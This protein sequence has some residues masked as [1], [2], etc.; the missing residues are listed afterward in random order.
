MENHDQTTQA[1]FKSSAHASAKKPS[2]EIDVERYDAYLKD[3]DLS[4]EQKRELL[5]ALWN[6][7][8]EFVS[9]GFGVHPL[10]QA[11]G[12]PEQ[13]DAILSADVLNALDCSHKK[14]RTQESSAASKPEPA[15]EGVE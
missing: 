4:D 11:C 3:S 8:V 13:S 1:L 2:V 7:I 9:L 5:Q 14:N 15:S 12:K 10:Q 6:V